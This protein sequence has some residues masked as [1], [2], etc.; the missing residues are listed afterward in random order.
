[1]RVLLGAEVVI[2]RLVV[3]LAGA[4]V[5]TLVARVVLERELEWWWQRR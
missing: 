1:M 3:V 4:R 2:F 5:I